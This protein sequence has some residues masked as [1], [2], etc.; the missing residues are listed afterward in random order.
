MLNWGR[1]VWNQSTGALCLLIRLYSGPLSSFFQ[2]FSYLFHFI[3]QFIQDDPHIQH[4]TSSSTH[5]GRQERQVW[6]D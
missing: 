2:S 6:L 1:G 5:K 4:I 3:N